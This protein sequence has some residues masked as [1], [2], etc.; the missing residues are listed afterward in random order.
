MVY[1]DTETEPKLQPVG[2]EDLPRGA[3][4]Q[5]GARADIRIRD[6]YIFTYPEPCTSL[7]LGQNDWIS[8]FSAPQQACAT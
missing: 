8:Y 6:Y 7:P 5:E 4:F 1:G 2:E 3:N